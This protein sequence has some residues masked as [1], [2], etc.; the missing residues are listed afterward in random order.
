VGSVGAPEILVIF[1]VAL[2]VLGPERLPRAA[3]Q[4]GKAIGEFRRVTAGFQDEVRSAFEDD[5]PAT[6]ASTAAVAPSAVTPSA[7]APSAVAPS[8]VTPPPPDGTAGAAGLGQ[9]RPALPL[10]SEIP[11]PPD[12]PGRN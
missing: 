5:E 1:L 12:D 9:T 3:R 8:A 6:E 2:I 4:A 7:V 11:P 10:E